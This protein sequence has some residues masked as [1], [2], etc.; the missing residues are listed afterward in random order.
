ML[1]NGVWH[2]KRCE[3]TSWLERLCCCAGSKQHNGCQCK[4]TLL[5]ML[6]LSNGSYL[7]QPNA[8]QEAT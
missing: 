7:L 1:L 2:T 4:G 8:L 5:H 6:G 3:A